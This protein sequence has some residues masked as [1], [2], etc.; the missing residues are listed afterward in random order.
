MDAFGK[1]SGSGLTGGGASGGEL[2]CCGVRAR[3]RL[4]HVT[5]KLGVF[6]RMACQALGQHRPIQRKAVWRCAE[7]GAGLSLAVAYA[8]IGVIASGFILSDQGL[9]A[10]AAAKLAAK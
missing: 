8:P 10:R 1:I 7:G 9:Q 3:S 5:A 2:P 6:E 4:C